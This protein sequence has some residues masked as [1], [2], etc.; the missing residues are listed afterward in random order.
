MPDPND[1][2]KADEETLPRTSLHAYKEGGDRERDVKGDPAPDTGIA[3]GAD[4]KG[5]APPKH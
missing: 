4:E 5:G 3:D 2:T 1:E